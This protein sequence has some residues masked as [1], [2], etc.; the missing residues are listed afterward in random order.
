MNNNSPE[1]Q[2]DQ[3][4]ESILYGFGGAMMIIGAGAAVLTA[5]HGIDIHDDTLVIK[6]VVETG[7]REFSSGFLTWIGYN[8]IRGRNLFTGQ[9]DEQ[10]DAEPNG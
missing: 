10:P 3:S 7:A 5:V 9:G 6:H 8:I 2:V 4:N 1:N